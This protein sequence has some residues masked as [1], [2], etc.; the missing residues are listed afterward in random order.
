MPEVALQTLAIVGS[1]L[2]ELS[3][4]PTVLQSINEY[5]RVHY[6]RGKDR[7]GSGVV[8]GSVLPL[9]WGIRSF[10]HTNQ[11]KTTVLI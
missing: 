6:I 7:G 5:H 10:F 9:V 2:P 4:V 11:N 3:S 8:Y 1:V